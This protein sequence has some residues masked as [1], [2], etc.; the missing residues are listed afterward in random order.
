MGSIQM[1]KQTKESFKI[2]MTNVLKS[3]LRENVCSN[4]QVRNFKK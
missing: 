3:W 2:T 4:K 1:L